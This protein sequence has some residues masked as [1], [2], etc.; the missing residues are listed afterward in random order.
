MNRTTVSLL[1][2][3]ILGIEVGVLLTLI[4]DSSSQC[5]ET[6]EEVREIRSGVES[7]RGDLLRLF[8]RRTSGS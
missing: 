7:L 2:A 6:E 3:F 5:R 8:E 1:G 4:F